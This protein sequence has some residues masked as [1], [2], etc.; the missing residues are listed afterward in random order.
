MI[1]PIGF[2]KLHRE[3][4]SKPIW[5]KSTVEQ[6]VILVTLLMMANFKSN[7]WEWK[8]E[9]FEVKPGQFI[10][11]LDSIVKECGK[12]VSIQNVRTALTRFEKLDFLTDKPTKEGRLITIANWDLYQVDNKQPNKPNNKD[13]TKG[14]QTPNKDLTPKEEGNK[15][16]K[17]KNE[18]YSLADIDLIV[19][20]IRKELPKD[21]A[22]T[23]KIAHDKLPKLIKEHGEDELINSVKNYIQQ[24]KKDRVEFP[25]KNYM[26]ESTF[27]NG[28][29]LDFIGVETQTKEEPKKI[30]VVIVEG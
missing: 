27:W 1:Q 17:E 13:L 21:M 10:T 23:S 4:A 25:K 29:Y 20:R 22:K 9:K 28:R 14:S 2:I 7:E 18:K 8:G 19:A 5:L 6:K 24:I 16:N 11:S 30:N 3:L 15:D 26:N 12:G